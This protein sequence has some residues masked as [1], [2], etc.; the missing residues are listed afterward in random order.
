V[1]AATIFCAWSTKSA[2]LSPLTAW[3]KKASRV[4]SFS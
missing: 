1:A 4:L 3:L 2:M